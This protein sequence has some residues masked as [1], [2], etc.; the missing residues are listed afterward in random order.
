MWHHAVEALGTVAVP[1]EWSMVLVLNCSRTVA[2]YLYALQAL[3]PLLAR[4]SC[5]PC[6][7]PWKLAR[8]CWGHACLA[9]QAGLLGF[10]LCL[11]IAAR[12]TGH[13]AAPEPTST[14]R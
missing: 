1:G 14:G 11:K 9:A 10:S 8:V 7:A 5:S 12:P 6:Q 4:T 13:M 3:T 2:A